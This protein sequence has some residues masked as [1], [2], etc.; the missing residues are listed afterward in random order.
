MH[1][2][3]I[4][5]KKIRAPRARRSQ[6]RPS[7]PSSSLAPSGNGRPAFQISKLTHH[8]FLPQ[9]SRNPNRLKNYTTT[10]PLTPHPPSPRS[11]PPHQS[12]TQSRSAPP[13]ARPRSTDTQPSHRPSTTH[14]IPKQCN[15]NAQVQRNRCGCAQFRQ[16]RVGWG[17]GCFFLVSFFTAPFRRGDGPVSRCG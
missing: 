5:P 2:P 6:S 17:E 11:P 12:I 3:N 9:K 15:S 10:P 14:S 8:H 16:C 1:P 7:N 13:R 4:K